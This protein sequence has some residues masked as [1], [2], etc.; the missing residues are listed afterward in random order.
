M[1]PEGEI[2]YLVRSWP[3]LSQTFV[4]DEVLGLERLGLRLRIVALTEPDE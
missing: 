1:P 4:L 3:R 2:V